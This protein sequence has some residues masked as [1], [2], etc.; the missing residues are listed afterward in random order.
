[1]IA[2]G[3]KRTTRSREWLTEQARYNGPSHVTE[4]LMS[5]FFYA[6][7]ITKPEDVIPYL[8]GQEHHWKKGYSACGSRIRCQAATGSWTKSRQW[9]T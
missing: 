4:E 7:E 2:A 5:R 1:M 3:A 9:E 6:H 8:A